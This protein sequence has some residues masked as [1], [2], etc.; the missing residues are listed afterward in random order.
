[1][2]KKE[3]ITSIRIVIAIF[4][5]D[6]KAK[7]ALKLLEKDESFGMQRGAVIRHTEDGKVKIHETDDMSGG[8]GAAIGGAVG[9]AFGIIAGPAAIVT[10]AI[11][12]GIGG[13]LAGLSDGGIPDHKLE[14]IG[15]ALKPGMSAVASIVS[16]DTYEKVKEGMMTAGA[17][18][19]TEVPDI[20]IIKDVIAKAETAVSGTSSDSSEEE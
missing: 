5:D 8:K 6:D 11:G 17:F 16:I 4:D 13:L 1:M 14:E 19:L 9:A 2:S 10:G 20:F 3:D 7:A 12:A 18:A 15:D